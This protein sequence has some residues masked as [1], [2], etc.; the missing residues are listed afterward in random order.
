MMGVEM[1]STGEVACFG[2]DRYEAYLKG[3][4][5]TGFA[6]PR[7]AIF[8]SIGG[9][10]QKEEMLSSVEKLNE[11]GFALYCSKGSWEYYTQKGIQVNLV[12]WPNDESNDG[13]VTSSSKTASAVSTI[14]ELISKKDFD[15]AINLPIRGSGAYRVSACVSMGYK[16]RRMTIDNGIPLITDVKCAKLFVEV[17]Y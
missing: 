10:F 8:L 15:L 1:L 11:L 17:R 16:T 7:R 5:A 2:R 9:V 14:A 12:E 6:L 4:V 3:L 13:G